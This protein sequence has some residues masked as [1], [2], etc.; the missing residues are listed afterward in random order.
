[1]RHWWRATNSTPHN[2]TQS[3]DPCPGSTA[4]SPLTEVQPEFLKNT[5]TFSQILWDGETRPS[6]VDLDAGCRGNEICH[7]A[8]VRGRWG[9]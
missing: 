5:V 2:K 1:M 9:T 4:M 3:L 6:S 7:G 8:V